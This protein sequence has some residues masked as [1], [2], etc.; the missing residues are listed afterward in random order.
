MAAEKL[1]KLLHETRI[2]KLPGRYIHADCK[3]HPR[4]PPE[5]SHCQGCIEHPGAKSGNFGLVDNPR[6]PAI[7][8]QQ[9]TLRVLPTHKSFGTSHLAAGQIHDRLN[10]QAQM[11]CG[12]RSTD[13]K[14]LSTTLVFPL[15]QAGIEQ[16]DAAATGSLGS[17]HGLI[18]LAQ[19]Q[20]GI[21]IV[22]RNNTDTKAGA[23]N[24]RDTGADRAR[25]GNQIEKILPNLEHLIAIGKLRQDHH[26][27]ITA[28]SGQ[29]VNRTQGIAQA[30][31]HQHQQ[32]VSSRMAIVVIHSLEEIEIEIKDSQHHAAD[33]CLLKRM[34]QSPTKQDTVR[35]AGE[36]IF[37]SHLLETK[38]NLAA[39]KALRDTVHDN[40][41][42]RSFF[43][44]PAAN[45]PHVIE[46]REALQATTSHQGDHQ[47]RSDSLIREKF[48]F[49]FRPRWQV[50]QT[51]KID[52]AIGTQLSH[53][54]WEY[55]QRNVLQITNLRLYASR[56]PL[57]RVAHMTMLLRELE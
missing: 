41:Q 2:L 53:P 1:G 45:T 55:I 54:P 31:C 39:L 36:R 51:G 11:P 5:A 4:P 34:M 48:T 57:V 56:T 6:K 27:F 22:R 42:D 8:R 18:R 3:V 44:A 19:Q 33:T 38:I 23:H 35:Q 24:N 49:T 43:L 40:P 52:D 20:I 17:V 14:N 30:I 25:P 28:Q 29:R 32:L 26:E 12:D 13:G 9:T 10:E 50:A 15:L 16:L 7:R 21:C 46:A 37:K 47:Q